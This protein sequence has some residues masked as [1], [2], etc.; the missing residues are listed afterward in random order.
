MGLVH[1]PKSAK[2]LLKTRIFN[3]ALPFIIIFVAGNRR[4]FKFGMCVEHRKSQPMTL[5]DL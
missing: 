3:L 1:Y 4:H 5:G 2:G